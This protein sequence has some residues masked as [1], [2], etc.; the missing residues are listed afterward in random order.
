MRKLI[1]GL[2]IKFGFFLCSVG[3]EISLSKSEKK[4]RRSALLRQ[5]QVSKK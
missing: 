3:I 2:I 4:E 5:A 1:G